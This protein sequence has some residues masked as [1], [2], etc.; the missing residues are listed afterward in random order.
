MVRCTICVFFISA[1]FFI[2]IKNSFFFD[3]MNQFK[4]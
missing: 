1:N 2:E 3:R 4:C